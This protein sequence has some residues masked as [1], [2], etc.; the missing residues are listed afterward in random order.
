MLP[1]NLHTIF[2]DFDGVLADSTRIKTDAFRELFKDYGNAAVD[3]IVDYHLLHGGISRVDKIRYGFEEILQQPLSDGAHQDLAE[4][5]S[6]IVVEKVIRS[7]WIN[8]AR[9]FL[10]MAY[11]KMRI[12]VISGTPDEELK[13]VMRKRKMDHYFSDIAG[14]PVKKPQHLNTFLQQ[15]KLAPENCL[16]VGDALTDYNAAVGAGMHFIGIQ[17]DNTFPPG[18]VVLPDCAGLMREIHKLFQ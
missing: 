12:I 9:E 18:T 2:F 3:A 4:Q 7:D 5:F 8:G 16:F 6:T 17:Q 11:N 15:Y 14:S 13:L 1:E 10:E